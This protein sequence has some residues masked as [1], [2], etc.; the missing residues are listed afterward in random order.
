MEPP[1]KNPSIPKPVAYAVN[2]PASR[3]FTL[4]E[5]LVVIAIIGILAA[6]VIPVVGKVRQSAART[7][8]ASNLRQVFNLYMLDVQENRGKIFMLGDGSAYS[9][10]MDGIATEYYGAEGKGIGQALGCPVQIELKPNILV[11]SA[12]NSRAP[13]TYSLNRDINRSLAS[14]YTNTPRAFA[15]FI[16]PPRTALA[17]DGND[18][19]NSPNYYTGI[20]GTGGRAPQ[21]P[22]NGK[23]NIVFLDGHVET[24]G[25]QSLINVTSVPGAGTPQA[26]FWFGE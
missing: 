19:D 6:I 20:M 22:H 18:S 25:D 11:V 5:L 23:A 26:M 4:T 8:C 12:Q 3:G 15:S 1:R 16:S 17:G 21:T 10:W 2:T 14:P 24:I 9:I 7:T 13:R